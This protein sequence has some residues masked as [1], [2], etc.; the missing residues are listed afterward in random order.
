[1][2]EHGVG[3]IISYFASRNISIKCF[4][5]AFKPKKKIVLTKN[6]IMIKHQFIDEFPIK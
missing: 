1:M 2:I 3:I 5:Q 6:T 4:V